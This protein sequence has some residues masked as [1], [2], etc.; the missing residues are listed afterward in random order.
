MT[1]EIVAIKSYSTIKLSSEKKKNAVK[2]EIEI[3]RLL[4]HPNIVKYYNV[5]ENRRNTHLIMEHGGKVNL[6]DIIDKKKMS[7]TFAIK[8]FK[9]I[10]EAVAYIHSLG[11]VHRD[12]K[13][14]NI[15]VNKQHEVKLVDF[16]FAVKHKGKKLSDILGTPNYMGPEIS[17][18][19]M[20]DGE[21]NDVWA[22]GVIFYFMVTGKYPFGGKNLAE[23]M[24][25]IRRARPS[26][27]SIKGS[28]EHRLLTK[29]FV[30]KESDRITCKDILK[31]KIF[32]NF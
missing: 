17:Q 26:Y 7:R 32:K 1:G 6:K 12:L 25:N 8:S 22:L 16:G 2:N 14:E 13:V 3:L 4:K 29:I 27:S 11:I 21:A 15:T 18:R 28:N 10:V 20:Y 5:I 24:S 30:A 9:M 31:H 19:R 23:L